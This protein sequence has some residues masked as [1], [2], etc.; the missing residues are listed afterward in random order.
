MREKKRFETL[1][2][3]LKYLFLK[4][5]SYQCTYQV[6]K[7]GVLQYLEASKTHLRRRPNKAPSGQSTPS[8][9]EAGSVYATSGPRFTKSWSNGGRRAS[10]HMAAA[11]STVAEVEQWHAQVQAQVVR[12]RV[13]AKEPL[14]VCTPKDNS[15]Q[16]CRSSC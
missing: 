10:Q 12:T 2:N 15:E 6:Q 14:G 5:S 4:K 11:I 7:I 8:P 13:P 3:Q 9:E 1:L 16:V